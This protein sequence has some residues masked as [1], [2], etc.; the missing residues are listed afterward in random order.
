[1]YTEIFV[2]TK[3]LACLRNYLLKIKRLLTNDVVS[4]EQLGPDVFLVR[5]DKLE[6]KL[7]I[8]IHIHGFLFI[9]HHHLILRPKSI[10]P[11]K[12]KHSFVQTC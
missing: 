10:N 6:I 5:P 4:F 12:I 7:D 9:M 3:I 2:S 8:K 11:M 1:M